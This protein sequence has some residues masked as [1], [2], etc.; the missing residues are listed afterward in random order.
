[1][2]STH[3]STG[4]GPEGLLLMNIHRPE[5]MR[6]WRMAFDCSERQLRAAVAA[7]G[8]VVAHVRR[9]LRSTRG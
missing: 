9:Y 7:V 2:L 1:M 4:P 8:P 3:Y 6:Q 5:E